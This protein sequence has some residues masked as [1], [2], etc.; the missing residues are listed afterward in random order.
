MPAYRVVLAYDGTDFAGWQTQG[1][2]AGRARTVQGVLEAAL[3]R[4]AGG[5]HL[6][7][8]GAGRTDAGVHALGQTASFALPR[9]MEPLE[10]QRALNAMLPEDVRVLSAAL[11][12]AGFHARR[13]ALGKLYRYVLDSGGVPLPTRRRLAGHVPWR[14]DEGRVEQAAA[15]Y[16]GHQDFAALA[17][18]GSSVRTSVRTVTRSEA[19]FLDTPDA[20]G[21]RTLVFEV[22]ADG[23]LRRMVRSMVGGLLAVGRGA[24]GVDELRR[25]LAARDRRLWPPP[26]AACGLALVRVDYEAGFTRRAAR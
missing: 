14:L 6:P 10:L 2:A 1:R 19:R 23:F 21:G 4:L 18:T 20:A 25:A 17:S 26:A 8:A 16:L 3:A 9:G 7:V 22:E 13:S 15:L 24:L 11:A 12:P 5:E